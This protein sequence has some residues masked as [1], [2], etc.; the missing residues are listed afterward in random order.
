LS[1]SVG[2]SGLTARDQPVACV[3]PQVPVEMLV[4]WWWFVD[5]HVLD[6][7]I[8][9]LPCSARAVAAQFPIIQW[10]LEDEKD[11]ITLHHKDTLVSLSFTKWITYFHKSPKL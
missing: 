9:R 8:I 4:V 5:P 2:Y 3:L 11:D 1:H 6:W 10:G 7:N